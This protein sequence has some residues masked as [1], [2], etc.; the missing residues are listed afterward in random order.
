MCTCKWASPNWAHN[1][2]WWD[3]PDI[4][5]NYWSI[6]SGRRG[7]G[8]IGWVVWGGRWGRQGFGRSLWAGRT[9]CR[10]HS[11]FWPEWVNDLMAQGSA[12][13]CFCGE[14]EVWESCGGTGALS[15]CVMLYA[16]EG[17]SSLGFGL[18]GGSAHL[19]PLSTVCAWWR[20][21]C[22]DKH[23][24]RHCILL[25][26]FLFYFSFSCCTADCLDAPKHKAAEL[27][28]WAVPV[29]NS[30]LMFRD[31]TNTKTDKLNLRMRSH[32]IQFLVI[33]RLYAVNIIV[34]VWMLIHT[35][36]VWQVG[37]CCAA[38]FSLLGKIWISPWN[39]ICHRTL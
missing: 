30:C 17:L 11:Q 20:G 32:C 24:H 33:T 28:D 37:W 35:S 9:T 39:E 6:F 19:V 27:W 18:S 31:I 8:I 36:Q 13:V 3:T 14:G 38:C 2:M 12:S 23:M 22:K 25:Y 10:W 29:R 5:C 34:H 26:Y 21:L 16:W 1:Q 4:E 7:W 15:S